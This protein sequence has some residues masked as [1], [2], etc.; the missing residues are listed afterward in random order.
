MSRFS[1]SILLVIVFC[2]ANIF[3]AS[4]EEENRSKIKGFGVGAQITAP[5]TAPDV[6]PASGLSLRLWIFDFAALEFDLFMLSNSP[7]FSPRLLMKVLNSEIVDLYLGGG[8][9]LFTHLDEKG[10]TLL[11]LPIQGISG[12]EIRLTPHIALN[13][14]LGIFGHSGQVK[15][16][17]SGIGL[18]YYF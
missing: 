3:I 8:L 17:T 9:S 10:K 14:E 13:A 5:F 4:A 2:L 18:H 6:F 1:V 16:V 15:G 11:F 12:L 7:S